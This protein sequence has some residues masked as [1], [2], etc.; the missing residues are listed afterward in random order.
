MVLL[1]KEVKNLKN[2]FKKRYGRIGTWNNQELAT[3]NFNVDG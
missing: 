3:N 2:V 1:E